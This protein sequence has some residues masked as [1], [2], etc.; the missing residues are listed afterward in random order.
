MIRGK[1]KHC[2]FKLDSG[3]GIK[4]NETSPPHHKRIENNIKF[5]CRQLY[6]HNKNNLTAVVP[7]VVNGLATKALLVT[8]VMISLMSFDVCNQ[9]KDKSAL[10]EKYRLAGVGKMLGY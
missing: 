8:G 6:S 9:L 4:D 2:S 3:G 5:P 7:C 1:S 10:G